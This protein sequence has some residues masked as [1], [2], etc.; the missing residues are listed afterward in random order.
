MALRLLAGA[1]A[2]LWVMIGFPDA[3]TAGPVTAPPA[4]WRFRL[5]ALDLIALRDGRYVTPNDGT[6]FGSKAGPAAV[7]RLLAAAGQATD[8]ITLDVDALLVRAPGHLVLIDTGL[9]PA[10]HGVL[11][12]SLAIVGISPG[13]IT[14][15]LI[16]H[17]HPDHIGGLL[18][19]DGRSAF[20]TAVIR[21]SASEWDWMQRQ[22]ETRK[23]AAVIA[24]QVRSFEPG[25][26]VL[27]GIT[28][29]ALYGHTPG[30]V[31]YEIT[32]RGRR[33]EDIGDTAHS[34]IVSLAKPDWTGGIDENPAAGAATRRQ[35][36][37]RLAATR[38]LVFSPHF[39]FPGVGRIVARGE[40]FAWKPL[41]APPPSRRPASRHPRFAR[42]EDQDPFPPLRSGGGGRP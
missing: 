25:R 8:R 28:P 39:P 10:D 13:Q 6:D 20:P 38:E 26:R 32:S 37:G 34:S 27:P 41:S 21:M 17:A 3:M 4:A 14:D 42:E 23:L 11:M 24:P 31:G 12:R 40:G 16:T 35:A 36:L 30:H 22:A 7:S 15:V 5:G 33:L 29:I 9:G 18:A 1:V 2:V 19:A